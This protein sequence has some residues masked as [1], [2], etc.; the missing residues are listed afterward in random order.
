MDSFKNFLRQR[1][2]EIPAGKIKGHHIPFGDFR[3]VP[4]R[5]HILLCGDAAGLVEPITGEG[6]AFAMQSGHLAAE[7]IREAAAAGNPAAALGFYQPRYETIAASFRHAN[8]LRHFLFPRASQNLFSKILP[9][10]ASIPR[11][12]L[13]LMADEITYADYGKFL[14]RKA[15]VAPLR[16]FAP[17]PRADLKTLVPA[18]TANVPSATSP[19]LPF[20]E[21]PPPPASKNGS[22]DS[23]PADASVHAR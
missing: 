12:H 1:F 23:S 18:A 20:A 22:N 2:G 3:R 6:I 4:G 8:R 15:V 9:R 14:L 17:R 13:D 11:R 16:F 19:P 10:T 7:A 21:T 5:D